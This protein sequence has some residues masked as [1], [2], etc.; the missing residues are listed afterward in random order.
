VVAS[1]ATHQEGKEAA[2]F[3]AVFRH[4]IVLAILVGLLV[5]CYAYVC[6]QIIPIQ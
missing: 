6:P 1:T 3:K 4:S 5:L 2:I